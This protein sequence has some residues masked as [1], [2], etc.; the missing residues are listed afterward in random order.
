VASRIG[1]TGTGRSARPAAG[2]VGERSGKWPG[3]PSRLRR[4]VRPVDPILGAGRLILPLGGARPCLERGGRG[5]AGVRAG[6]ALEGSGEFLP[7]LPAG[8]RREPAGFWGPVWA[9]PDPHPGVA[10]PW[11]SAR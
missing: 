6:G 2:G 1:L 4:R 3:D 5:R 10:Y 7:A 11:W 9:L 8:F